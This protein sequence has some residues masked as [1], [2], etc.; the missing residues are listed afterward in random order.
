MAFPQPFVLSFPS[1]PLTAIPTAPS[2]DVQAQGRSLRGQNETMM[3]RVIQPRAAAAALAEATSAWVTGGTARATAAASSA[4]GPE[5]CDLHGNW[6]AGAPAAAGLPG[7]FSRRFSMAAQPAEQPPQSV[8]VEVDLSAEEPDLDDLTPSAVS[9]FPFPLAPAFAP[10]LRAS[11]FPAGGTR[12]E[13]L[14]LWVLGCPCADHGGERGGNV[15]LLLLLL[16]LPPLALA[17][18]S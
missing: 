1:V 5:H 6:A 18:R 11:I 13:M 15:L 8:T 17:P 12:A 14:P 16:P 2:G 3:R 4:V 9:P 10:L 7:L